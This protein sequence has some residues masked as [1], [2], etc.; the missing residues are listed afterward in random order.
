[1]VIALN[2]KDKE[3]IIIMKTIQI[4]NLKLAYDN[5]IV[6]DDISLEIPENKITILVGANG[7]GKSTMLRSFA[8]LLKPAEGRIIF[9][10]RD[11]SGV[12]NKQIAK[13]L[14]ILPQNPVVSG[15]IKVRELVEM[16]RFP[17]QNWKNK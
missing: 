7:C 4:E 13:E 9:N 6:I 15:S 8:R 11:M 16:G 2:I 1:M 17:Y 14:A 10:G 12:S 5:H 3:V